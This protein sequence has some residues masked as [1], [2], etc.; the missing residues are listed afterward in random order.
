MEGACNLSK[1]GNK[2]AVIV[3]KTNELLEFLNRRW[4]G[5]R[6]DGVELGA[7]HFDAIRRNPEAQ[8]IDPVGTEHALGQLAK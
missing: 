2:R 5:P 1:V 6:G 8:P 3:D 4:G 7:V